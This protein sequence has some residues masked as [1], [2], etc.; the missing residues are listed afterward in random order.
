MGAIAGLATIGLSACQG[1]RWYPSEISPDEYVL[2]AVITE[3]ERMIA[4]YEATVAAG[5]GPV[6]LLRRVLDDHKSHLAALRE[7]LPSPDERGGKPEESV[8]S[9]S[10][11][12]DPVAETAVSVASLRVAESSAAGARGR[13]SADVSDA[14][15]AQLI[16][17]IG[18]CELGHAH[19]LS[20][21]HP[22]SE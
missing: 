9:P 2:R 1:R 16:A 21:K 12:P 6:D 11:T 20:R 3:K 19:L 10:P 5:E 4:R 14:G 15:L 18:A 22:E 13:Q 17:S 8:S 7:R